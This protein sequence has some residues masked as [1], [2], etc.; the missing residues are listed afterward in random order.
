[1]RSYAKQQKKLAGRIRLSTMATHDVDQGYAWVILT[2]CVI[3]QCFEYV[4][5]IGIYYMAIL[6]KFQRGLSTYSLSTFLAWLIT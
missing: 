4:A 5:T 6:R 2:I 3:S 1:M